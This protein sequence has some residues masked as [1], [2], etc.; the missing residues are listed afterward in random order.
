MKAPV[1]LGMDSE[2]KFTSILMVELIMYSQLFYLSIVAISVLCTI[3]CLYWVVRLYMIP[4]QNNCLNNSTE[5]LAQPEVTC[6]MVT[7]KDS[8]RITLA[9]ASVKNFI[10][11]TYPFK[12]LIIVNHHPTRKVLADDYRQWPKDVFEFKVDK[13]ADRLTLGDIRNISLE[14]VAHDACWTTWDDD[15]WR[16]PNYLSTLINYMGQTGAIAV[17][18]QN[19]LEYNKN[20]G[21]IWGVSKT[22][23]FPT[24]MGKFDRRIQYLSKDTL[25]DVHIIENYKSLGKVSALN[26]D[27]KLYIRLVHE[28]N[29]STYVDPEKSSILHYSDTSAFQERDATESEQQ[30]VRN[31]FERS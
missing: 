9:R 6:L 13:K 20:T 22:M 23:G 18:F 25:E 1:D 31:V 16:A 10:D 24:V 21:F 19:R 11:Q 29:T 2:T 7:G 4:V 28:N 12:K 3:A 30:F 17:V 8:E 5:A 26:N 15:D 14:L 27:P